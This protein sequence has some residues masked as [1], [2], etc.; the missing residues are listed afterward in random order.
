MVKDVQWDKRPC[1]TKEGQ[2]RILNKFGCINVLGWRQAKWA[3]ERRLDLHSR[4]GQLLLP[5]LYEN[6]G[7]R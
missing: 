5:D 2:E 6:W 3:L 7:C 1:V 4:S